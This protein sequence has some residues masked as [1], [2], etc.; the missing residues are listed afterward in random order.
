MNATIGEEAAVRIAPEAAEA[1]RLAIDATGGREVFFAGSLDASNR[2]EVVRVCA[3]GHESAVP[4]LLEAVLKGEVVLHNHPSGNIAPSEADLSLSVQFANNANGVYIIDNAVTRVYVVIEPFID[5]EQ[6]KL[7]ADE[8]AAMLAEGGALSSVVPHYEFRRQQQDMMA[9][10]SRAFNHRG[11]SV[12]EAPTGVGKTVAYLVPALLWAIRN[13]ERVVVSTRTINL[14]EQIMQ[15]DLPMLEKAL[16]KKF[17]AVL[18]KGRSNYLCLRKLERALSEATLF[19]DGNTQAS[20]KAI[21]EWAEKT[22]DGTLSDLPFVPQREIWERC[23][24]EAD[25]CNPGVCPAPGKCFV[26]K[27]RRE[28]A[29]ADLLV[30][31][32]HMLFSDLA[33]KKEVGNFSA[34]GVLPSYR[35]VVFDEAHSIED[36]ATEYFGAEAT[37]NGAMAAFGRFLRVERNHERGLIPYLKMKVVKLGGVVEFKLLEDILNVIDNELLPAL[38]AARASVDAAF[39]AVRSFTAERC[40]KVGREIRWRLTDDVLANLELREIHDVYVSAAV[41]ELLHCNRFSTKLY[42]KL[43]EIKPGPDEVESPIITEMLQLEAFRARL[44]RVATVLAEG[45]SADIQP[46]TVR[47]VEI[48]SDDSSIVRIARCPL[49]VS[50]PLA[51]WVYENLYSVV[52]TSATLAV[53]RRFDYFMERVGLDKVAHRPIECIPL[54]SP[55]D[56]AKQAMLC[57]PT[58]IPLPDEKEFADESVEY[59]REILEITR[60]HA[61]VLFTSFGAMD[62]AYRKLQAGL[63]AQGIVAL[64]QGQAS[65][66]HLLSEFRRDISSVLFA[67]DSFWE[68]VDVAGDALQCVILTKLPFRVPTEP[69]VEAR[70]EAIEANGGNAFMDYTVPQAVIK[71]RQGFGRLIRRSTDS[72]V[73]VVLDRRVITKRYGRAFLQSLPGMRIVKGPRRGMMLAL[74]EFFNPMRG[75]SDATRHPD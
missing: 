27:A 70:A 60:G 9:S 55:F 69:I 58:E 67:T 12:I 62:Y 48:D 16:K 72:G 11:L 22:K 8:L 40:G 38:S 6:V 29:K 14:Q 74:E 34:L 31:N 71:F 21:S 64:K 59:I 43:R 33:I 53:E 36:V 18:V 39:G 61:F 57:I 30:V 45:T 75:S 73:I 3:R 1:M 19:D 46:N 68:G 20:F 65:R 37:R 63:R 4:A 49:E 32:H 41:E 56:Y 26:G 51:D 28:M 10:V 7:D 13:T 35:R 24:S 15:K 25:T 54:D 23:C 5:K 47:W 66:T 50:G 42:N 2:V 52:M 17:S 44:M